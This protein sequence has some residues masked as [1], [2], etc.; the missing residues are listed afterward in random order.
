MEI[1]FKQVPYTIKTVRKSKYMIFGTCM[2]MSR[3]HVKIWSNE[4]NNEIILFY[5]KHFKKY[6]SYSDALS[7][8]YDV[9]IKRK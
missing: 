5:S 7:V 6:Y 9:Q 1:I 8:G 3:R 2:Y 4:P